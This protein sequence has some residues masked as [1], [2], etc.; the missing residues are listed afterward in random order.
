MFNSWQAMW[1]LQCFR[2]DTSQ[3]LQTDYTPTMSIL[4]ELCMYQIMK[5]L[6]SIQSNFSL[7]LFC[8]CEINLR[9]ILFVVSA[10]CWG[11]GNNRNGG[12]RSW[13]LWQEVWVDLFIGLWNL[14][15]LSVVLMTPQ[16]DK[17]G[18]GSWRRSKACQLI[19]L[20]VEIWPQSL[21]PWAGTDR[22]M[23]PPAFTDGHLI[24]THQCNH[25]SSPPSQNSFKKNMS[26][27]HKH[28]I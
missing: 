18:G 1:W 14:L 19:A 16:H 21:V 6:F 15:D 9:T 13:D 28:S 5:Y 24:F 20:A 17:A 23:V 12:S 10:V 27:C 25:C 8:N 22:R 2:K 3:F 11:S 7:P 26:N 4:I